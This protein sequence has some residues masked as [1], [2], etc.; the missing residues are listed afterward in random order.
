MS[1]SSGKNPNRKLFGAHAGGFE[2]NHHAHLCIG[3]KEMVILEVRDE[4]IFVIIEEFH[5]WS[6]RAETNET[7][8]CTQ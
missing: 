3:F 4:L 7:N 8:I 6:L 1:I 2:E 5:F